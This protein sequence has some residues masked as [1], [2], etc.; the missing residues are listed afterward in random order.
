MRRRRITISVL[1]YIL[2]FFVTSGLAG[3]ILFLYGTQYVPPILCLWFLMLFFCCYKIHQRIAYRN[4][5]R[6]GEWTLQ[7]LDDMDG[8]AFEDLTCDILAANGFDFAQSTQASIDFG[9]DVL[10]EKEGILYAIQCKRYTAPVGIEAVQQVYAG[11]AFYD[12]HV[13]VVLTNQH[14]TASARQLAEKIGVILWD[15]RDLEDML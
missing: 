11:C 2:L 9:V 14:F 12:C 15:R 4:I 10:A 7:D 5:Y 6:R 8:Y 3:F 1:L 13:A